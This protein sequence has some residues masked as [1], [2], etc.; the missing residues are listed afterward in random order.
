[1]PIALTAGMTITLI[2]NFSNTGAATL[3]VNGLGSTPAIT[4]NGTSALISGDIVSG[5]AFTVTW[6]GTRWQL[7]NPT[8]NVPASTPVYAS[9]T[10]THDISMTGAQNIAHGLGKIPKYIRIT[11]VGDTSNPSQESVAVYNG[12]SCSAIAHAAIV[13]SSP[14]F[15]AGAATA[16]TA[17]GD[18]D[19]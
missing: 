10:T 4:K 12:S 14:T 13:G 2:A 8:A 7:Q 9:G 3:A 5:Q 16:V 19:L 6:D 15:A 17:W 11:N 18:S 1:M